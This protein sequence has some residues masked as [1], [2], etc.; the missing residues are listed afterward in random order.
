[1]YL[2]KVHI[3][4][5]IIHTLIHN[6][7]TRI[8]CN[9]HAKS[10]VSSTCCLEHLS[11]V[12]VVGVCAY[13][14]HMYDACAHCNLHLCVCVCVC[15]RARAR[16]C[17]CVC[18]LMYICTGETFDIHSYESGLYVVIITNLHHIGLA[19]A[20]SVPTRTYS[21]EV[22]TLWYRPPDVLLGSTDYTTSLDMW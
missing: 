9:T 12:F 5:R 11:R 17:V 18:V 8:I 6:I 16:A 10:F 22:V 20:K 4:V 19:R 1:M 2:T 13:G 21:H 15:V 7:H 3:H 14:M